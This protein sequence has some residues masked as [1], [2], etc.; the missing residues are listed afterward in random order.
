MLLCM[1]Y[2]TLA[3]CLQ[4][5]GYLSVTAGDRNYSRTKTQIV[6]S[7]GLKLVIVLTETQIVQSL[8]QYRVLGLKLVIVQS[9]SSYLSVT[10]GDRNCLRIETTEYRKWTEILGDRI[11][12]RQNIESFCL[13]LVIYLQLSGYQSVTAGDRN[14]RNCKQKFLATLTAGDRI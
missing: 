4:L 2:E 3:L 1:F 8:T 6:Q 12:K 9:L 10:A 11:Q 14:D 7:L 5:S 13:Y